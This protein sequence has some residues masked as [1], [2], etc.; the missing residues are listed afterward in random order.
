MT[1][2]ADAISKLSS[3]TRCSSSIVLCNL[4]EVHHHT[5]NS[6][7]TALINSHVMTVRESIYILDDDILL[8]CERHRN[9]LLQ[10][11]KGLHKSSKIRLIIRDSGG[12]GPVNIEVLSASSVRHIQG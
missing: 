8:T 3:Y 7:A 11:V 1:E 12:Q 10:T 5:N 2:S 4:K 9:S 6:L